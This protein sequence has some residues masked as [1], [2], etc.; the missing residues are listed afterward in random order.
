MVNV[1]LDTPT[2]YRIRTFGAIGQ[3]SAPNARL[4]A[5]PTWCHLGGSWSRPMS[6]VSELEAWRMS[7][8]DY[9]AAI[10]RADLGA[11]IEAGQ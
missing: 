11:E 8:A 2:R 10:A 5:L 3:D 4:I 7:D 1:S 6:R 9:E